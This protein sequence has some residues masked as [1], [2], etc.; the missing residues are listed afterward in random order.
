M[1]FLVSAAQMKSYD[2]NTIEKIGIPALV[3][4]ER[5]AVAVVEEIRRRFPGTV[6]WENGKERKLTVLIVAGCGN[7]GE[8]VLPSAAFSG[9]TAM[10][11]P[12][13]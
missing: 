8:T 11:F 3:L 2:S 6:L 10:K 7:N 4:M 1:Q 13:Y 12:L 5:A 9:N